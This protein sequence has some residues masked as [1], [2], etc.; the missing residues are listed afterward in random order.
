MVC[1]YF[2]DY[3]RECVEDIQNLPKETITLCDSDSYTQCPFYLKRQNRTTSC[4]HI[5]KCHFFNYFSMDTF[6]EFITLTKTYCLSE[7]HVSCARYTLKENE[8]QVPDDLSPDG[9][10]F[11]LKQ[12]ISAI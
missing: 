10:K 11:T 7:N 2:I 5:G 4:K 3:V 6:Q 1:P 9:S 8:K 12:G